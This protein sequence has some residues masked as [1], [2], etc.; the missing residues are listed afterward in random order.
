MITEI[1]EKV[2]CFLIAL[3]P[4]TYSEKRLLMCA[5]YEN[6]TVCYL[7]IY[8][9]TFYIYI[10]LSFPLSLKFVCKLLFVHWRCKNNIYLYLLFIYARISNSR[11]SL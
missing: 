10:Y 6:K 2:S 8:E 9:H 7:F 5:F 4:S 11:L 3:Q 1:A